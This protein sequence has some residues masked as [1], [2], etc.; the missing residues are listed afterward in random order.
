LFNNGEAVVPGLRDLLMP[1]IGRSGPLRESPRM[2]TVFHVLTYAGSATAAGAALIA[3][4]AAPV[5]PRVAHQSI[6]IGVGALVTAA[7]PLLIT[8]MRFWILD[9]R[10]GRENQLRLAN[11][12]EQIKAAVDE[13]KLAARREAELKAAEAVRVVD[14]KIDVLDQKKADLVE[15]KALAVTAASN[16]GRLD[17]AVKRLESLGEITPHIGASGNKSRVMVVGESM[18]ITRSYSELFT[19]LGFDVHTAS[20]VAQAIQMVRADPPHWVILNLILSD[21]SGVDVLRAIRQEHIRSKV[22]VVTRVTD[23][24]VMAQLR[25]LKP[26]HFQ[27][28][29][30]DLKKLVKAIDP[31]LDLKS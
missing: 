24:A 31:S 7:S 23:D 21:G 4:A 13:A 8:M 2:R 9:R 22:A 6:L 19:E 20:G 17:A 16:A 1:T 10:E 29:P 3:Q 30:T 26:D 25:D 27:H 5:D 14:Q 18:E 11:I 28:R 15:T 12:P